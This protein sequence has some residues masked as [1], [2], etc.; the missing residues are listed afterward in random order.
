MLPTVEDVQAAVEVLGQFID[1][2]TEAGEVRKERNQ[3]SLDATTALEEAQA[4]E[5]A[6]GNKVIEQTQ[7]VI[8]L[9]QAVAFP[10][11]QPPTS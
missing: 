7:K 2:R 6:K 5:L 8:E 10:P 11:V 3:A 1:E 4:D 9:V